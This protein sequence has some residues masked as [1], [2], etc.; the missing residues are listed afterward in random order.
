MDSRIFSKQH[1]GGIA[2]LRQ[3][4]IVYLQVNDK[5]IN[6]YTDTNK[7]Y[8]RS[9][10]NE[11]MR[12]LE[13]NFIRISRNVVVNFDNAVCVQ[14]GEVIVN[15]GDKLSVSRRRWKE[16]NMAYMVYLSGEQ[17][18]ATKIDHSRHNA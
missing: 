6:I 4:E 13:K 12:K 18:L 14:D 10:L 9:S 7:Y 5:Y 1:G 3:S 8:V 17:Q 16:V 15:N 11:C 2:L